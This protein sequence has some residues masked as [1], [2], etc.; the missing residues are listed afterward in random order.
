MSYLDEAFKYVENLGY[1][2]G[3]KKY[4]LRLWGGIGDKMLPP[5]EARR[6]RRDIAAKMADRI[7]RP[8]TRPPPKTPKTPKT[9]KTPPPKTPPPPPPPPP[10]GE[11]D[12]I[13]DPDRTPGPPAYPPPPPPIADDLDA[14]M[15]QL[16]AEGHKGRA[17]KVTINEGEDLDAYMAQLETESRGRQRTAA[18]PAQDEVDITDPVVVAN[19]EARLEAL[20]HDPTPTQLAQMRDAIDASGAPPAPPPLPGNKPT[21][22]KTKRRD[23]K[24]VKE[25]Q[26]FVEQKNKKAAETKLPTADELAAH[27]TTLKR[28][29]EQKPL[30]PKPESQQAETM[31]DTLRKAFK[32]K[33]GEATGQPEEE[34][35]E[36]V[37]PNWVDEPV[38]RKTARI[39]AKK[40]SEKENPAV[41][42]SERIAAKREEAA[43]KKQVVNAV[44]KSMMAPS[45]DDLYEA[46]QPAD[47]LAVVDYI[48]EQQR[49]LKSVFQR[50][51][52]KVTDPKE[53][54]RM[55]DETY[56]YLEDEFV[57]LQ[58]PHMLEAQREAT[59]VLMNLLDQNYDEMQKTLAQRLQQAKDEGKPIEQVFEEAQQAAREEEQKKKQQQE[60]EKRNAP[61]PATPNAAAPTTDTDAGGGE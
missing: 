54:K 45:F 21:K 41:R 20:K 39:Q 35:E 1:N 48:S 28:K 33:F 5:R 25:G 43:L 56:Q 36:E 27:A 52:S 55:Y 58:Q 16:E 30:P 42:R 12:W 6:E 3:R 18:P 10:N 4:H 7:P 8:P 26:A 24:T 51:M 31:Q 50:S 60:E 47:K 14:Y 38:T 49:F 29:E 15:A 59:R 9:A 46:L 40:E 19:L 57:R 13:T 22:S 34:V 17:G 32:Q 2:V 61:L 53:L 37:D 11:D 23:E 44:Q